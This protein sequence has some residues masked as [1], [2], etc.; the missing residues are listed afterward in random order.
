MVRRRCSGLVGLFILLL[1]LPGCGFEPGL[2]EEQTLPLS[3]DL[4]VIGDSIGGLSA[5]L[6]AAR[7]GAAVLLFVEESLDESWI[8]EEGAVCPGETDEAGLLEEALVAYSRGSGKRWHFALIS[9]NAAKD[10][11]WLTQITGLR[12]LPEE[13]FR[14]LPENLSSVQPQRRLKESAVQEG[15]RIIAGVELKQLLFGSGGEAVGVSFCDSAGLPNQAYAPAVILADG[16]ILGDLESV[17]ELAPEVIT[18]S[19]RTKGRGRSIELARAAGLDLVDESLFSYVL[20]GE[21]E[22]GWA[23]VEPPPETLLI[24]DGQILPF[25][26]YRE[27]DLVERLI[28]SPAGAGYLLL[29]GGLAEEDGVADW[30]RYSDIAAFMES[31]QLDL[32]ELNRRFGNRNTD[33]WGCLVKPVA[34]YCL[35]GIAVEESGLVLQDGRPVEGLY[36]IGEAAG[37][38]NGDDVMPGVALTGALVWGRHLGSAVIAQ[39]NEH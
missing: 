19:W 36:A 9:Q 23:P 20:A 3:A 5:S 34:S 16:G 37:G 14:S 12:M 25:W 33:F 11:A 10:L 28:G 35:G 2:G 38:L 21:T 22:K 7:R 27:S 1:T 18:A 26:Q 29:A 30:T 8:W 6:E 17:A 24:I 32:T 13:D 4:I 15:V 39:Q 31:F